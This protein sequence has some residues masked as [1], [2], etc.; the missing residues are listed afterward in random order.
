MSE[1]FSTSPEQLQQDIQHQINFFLNEIEKVYGKIELNIFIAA[2]VI[3]DLGNEIKVHPKER[4]TFIWNFIAGY[5]NFAL[6]FRD[7]LAQSDSTLVN[8]NFLKFFGTNLGAV[9][10]IEY[11]ILE[12]DE[13]VAKSGV[14]KSVIGG[15]PFYYS[16]VVED[17]VLNTLKQGQFDAAPELIASGFSEKPPIFEEVQDLPSQFNYFA[18]VFPNAVIS[19]NPSCFIVMELVQG[20]ELDT[21]SD[22]A[23]LRSGY[24]QFMDHIDTMLRDF[25]IFYIDIH[26]RNGILLD[27]SLRT[28]TRLLKIIDLA[29]VVVVKTED[30]TVQM[31]PIKNI[32]SGSG[33][34][35]SIK[36]LYATSGFTTAIPVI[37]REDEGPANWNAFNTYKY[38][39]NVLMFAMFKSIFG[40]PIEA[41]L[42]LDANIVSQADKSQA[43]IILDAQLS[44]LIHITSSMYQGVN[45]PSTRVDLHWKFISDALSSVLELSNYWRPIKDEVISY[46][47]QIWLSPN[48]DK[49]LTQIAEEFFDIF[50]NHGYT[51]TAN[52]SKDI[53]KSHSQNQ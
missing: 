11:H 36:D 2:E 37:S 13:A 7:V 43:K 3:E 51:I 47:G 41:V 17:I 25:G 10:E 45:D 52:L 19:S 34:L 6:N 29:T 9:T 28:I 50:V 27:E 48:I 33:D 4:N 1:Q 14:M 38:M 32:A 18:E 5:V 12:G 53:R 40:M 35:L 15:G 30:E 24:I 21:I 8:I 49:P 46:L 22:M 23:T 42:K 31:L 20:I 44:R 26:G 16:A 39:Q